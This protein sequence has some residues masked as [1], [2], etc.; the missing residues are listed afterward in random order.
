MDI[1]TVAC[2]APPTR[3]IYIDMYHADYVELR[4]VAGFTIQPPASG[5][6]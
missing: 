2:D 5:A 1:Y 6:N 3:S 4:P